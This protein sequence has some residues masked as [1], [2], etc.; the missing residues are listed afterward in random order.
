MAQ[1]IFVSFLKGLESIIVCIY[2]QYISFR[3]VG[4]K[5]TYIPWSLDMFFCIKC[6]GK[7]LLADKNVYYVKSIW[8]LLIKP[9]DSK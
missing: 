4:V 8:S 1:N 3:T 6:K 9:P 2:R 7:K 5:I